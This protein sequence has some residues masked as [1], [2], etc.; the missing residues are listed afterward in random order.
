MVLKYVA[1]AA[2]GLPLA[3][4]VRRLI[5]QPAGMTETWAKVPEDRLG[6]TMDYNGEYRLE[7][8]I[9]RLR[10]DGRP[11]VPH[12]PKAALLQA[13]TG[14]LCGHAGLFSTLPDLIR[15]CRA[16]LAGKIVSPASLAEMAVNRTGICPPELTAK[17]GSLPKSAV[18]CTGICPP[19]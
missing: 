9:S 8:G 10:L 4:C 7:R 6:D 3:E 19:N 17:P 2:S 11:G 14:D 12:D 18:N 13:D 15:F 1:E 5:L 16:L